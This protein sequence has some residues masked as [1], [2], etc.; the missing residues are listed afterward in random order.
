MSRDT[1]NDFM[2]LVMSDKTI[3]ESH[4]DDWDPDW[5]KENNLLKTNEETVTGVLK[6]GPVISDDLASTSST[7]TI[8]RTLTNSVY[9]SV[10]FADKAMPS[11]SITSTKSEVSSVLSEVEAK[12]EHLL[13]DIELLKVRVDE[14]EQENKLLRGRVAEANIENKELRRRDEDLERRI[15]ELKLKFML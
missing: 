6:D 14:L 8:I 15:S 10:I 1:R 12:V 13:I 5:P 11:T 2:E 7:T 9:G 4:M 3:K